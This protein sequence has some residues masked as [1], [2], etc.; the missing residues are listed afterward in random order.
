MHYS[1][2]YRLKALAGVTVVSTQEE[3]LAFEGS[4]GEE[5]GTAM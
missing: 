1:S 5:A 2:H 4:N 3:P